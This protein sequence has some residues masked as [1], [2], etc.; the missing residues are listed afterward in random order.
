MKG[1]LRSLAVILLLTVFA[2]HTAVPPS[3]RPDGKGLEIGEKD[4]HGVSGK[5]IVAVAS[6]YGHPYH[7]RRTSNGEVYD[8][9]LLT[10]AH[11]SWPFHTLVK[12]THLENGRSVLVRINDRGPFVEGREIDLSREAARRLEMIE[13]GTARVRLEIISMSDEGSKQSFPETSPEPTVASGPVT[14]PSAARF[15]LQLGAFTSEKNAR[16]FLTRVRE[17]VPWLDV[18]IASDGVF[19]RVLSTVCVDETEGEA[20]RKRLLEAWLESL[21]RSCE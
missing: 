10:A 18:R 11:R 16:R 15:R 3:I 8:M 9:N 12:V 17:D 20:Y 19:Y 21:L 6:W 13:E 7:G 5:A 2:C 14:P 4:E 1:L